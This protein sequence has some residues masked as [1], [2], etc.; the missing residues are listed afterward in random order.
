M[1][2]R[3]TDTECVNTSVARFARQLLSK[4]PGPVGHTTAAVQPTKKRIARGTYPKTV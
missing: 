1:R 3:Q 4:F 2:M